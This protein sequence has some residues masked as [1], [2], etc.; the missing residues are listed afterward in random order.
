M[1]GD[2]VH[3]AWNWRR[4][5]SSIRACDSCRARTSGGKHR[6][7][8]DDAGWNYAQPGVRFPSWN[9]WLRVT[10]CGGG[11]IDP[12]YSCSLCMDHLGGGRP[13]H[14]RL[15]ASRWRILGEFANPG[16]QCTCHQRS[17]SPRWMAGGVIVV[18]SFREC[19]WSSCSCGFRNNSGSKVPT[20][21][22]DKALV[23]NARRGCQTCAICAVLDTIYV[24]NDCP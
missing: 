10:D 21:T 1:G 4:R 6:V 12:P 20:G 16:L 19:G 23:R 8:A 13:V 14:A 18:A 3:R 9:P 5:Y 7:L 11:R 22:S 2:D 17:S 15:A 24:P